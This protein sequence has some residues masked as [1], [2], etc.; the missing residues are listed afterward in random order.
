MP[1]LHGGGRGV[2]TTLRT[3]AFAVAAAA[4]VLDQVTKEW[5]LRLMA[6][7]PGGIR[8]TSFFDLV[9]V[10]NRGVSFGLFNSGDADAQRWILIALSLVIV[11]VLVVW[12]W[13]ANTPLLA[14]AIGLVIGGAIGNVVDRLRFG[15]VA[16]FLSFHLGEYYWPAFNVADAAIVCGVGLLLL[17]SLWP[18]AGKR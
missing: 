2:R 16:D 4:L 5:L 8:V 18:A 10:W 3:L 7:N 6:E 15:A 13:R 1:P 14:V 11:A 9:M 17:D 12:L